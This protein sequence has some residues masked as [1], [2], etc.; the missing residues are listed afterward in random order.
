[1]LRRIF[2]S[3]DIDPWLQSVDVVHHCVGVC[4][5]YLRSTQ[6]RFLTSLPARLLDLFAHAVKLWVQ[7]GSKYGVSGVLQAA[8][9]VPD[10]LVWERRTQ[11]NKTSVLLACC[12]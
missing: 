7:L 3:L 1:M 11:W 10:D 5:C 4:V 6:S 8:R 12:D 2:S 9:P